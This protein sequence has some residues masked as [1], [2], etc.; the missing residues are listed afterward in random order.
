MI[1]IQ[2][3][4]KTKKSNIFLLIGID[5][6]T[7]RGTNTGCFLASSV[8]ETNMICFDVNRSSGAIQLHVAR[9]PT[10]FDLHGP[11]SNVDVACGS[12]ITALHQA[13]V[14][15][16]TGECEAALVAASNICIYP[17]TAMMFHDMVF[18]N[19]FIY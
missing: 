7:M 1:F 6:E 18:N 15:L 17:G 9:I 19:S 11:V 14:A 4:K 5:P 12:S 16:R 8:D 2:T 13:M 3:L 10:A